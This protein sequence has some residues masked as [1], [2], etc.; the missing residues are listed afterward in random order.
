[1]GV[2]VE[3]DGAGTDAL[4]PDRLPH[5][6]HLVVGARGHDDHVSRV[7]I[8]NGRLDGIAGGI[9]SVDV[10]RSF[11]ADRDRYSVYRFFA[12]VRSDY[13]L[14][15]LLVIGGILIAVETA[16]LQRCFLNSAG[17]KIRHRAGDCCVAPIRDGQVMRDAPWS[18]KG[19]GSRPLRV[20][21]ESIVAREVLLIVWSSGRL[22]PSVSR[23]GHLLLSLRR[24]RQ[25]VS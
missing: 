4:Q 21:A 23:I 14:A 5:N 6:Q 15:A 1:M 7:G 24:N 3:N 10:T 20:V 11:A 16:Y 12:I 25:R 2:R 9:F 19:D 13:Q 18:D 17:G 22:R 8:V